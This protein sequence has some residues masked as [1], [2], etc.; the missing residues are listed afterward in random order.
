MTNMTPL[1][2]FR[3]LV[4]SVG[5]QDQI[6]LYS[7]SIL[8]SALALL[9]M[10]A[11][12]LVALVLTPLISG[13][14][15]TI[16][17]IGNVPNADLPPYLVAVVGLLAFKN[18]LM[19]SLSAMVLKRLSKIETGFGKQ[20]FTYNL[21]MPWALRADKPVI[22]IMRAAD[23][24]VMRSVISF[25]LPALGLP[26]LVASVVAIGIT[27]VVIQPV[28]AVTTIGY[29]GVVA[30]VLNLFVSKQASRVGNVE[31][32]ARNRTS[33][34]MLEML[35]ASKELILRKKTAESIDF[36]NKTHLEASRSYMHYTFL[37][38]SSRPLLEVALL[39]GAVLIG[40]VNYWVG[41]FDA[42]ISSIAL[43]GIAGFRIAPAIASIQSDYVSMKVTMPYVE[44]VL[45]E[46]AA[47]KSTSVR[48]DQN[49]EN[50]AVMLP[51]D[52]SAINFRKVNF[53]Y[54]NNPDR[55]VL[56][57]LSFELPLGQRFAIVGPSGSGKSTLVDLILGLL[58][59]TYG[60]LDIGTKNIL[61]ALPSWQRSIGYVPQ[62]VTLFDASIAQNVALTWGDDYDAQA[63]EDALNRA[64]LS[65][66][67][68]QLPEG[69]HTRIG[70]NGMLLSGG[71]RQRLGIARA[72]YTN[73]KVLV[74]DEAT[75]A[76]D[77]ATE[78][79]IA[80]MID[81]MEGSITIISI[82]HR[83]SSISQYENICYLAEG[84]LIGIGTFDALVSE[85]P[86]FA[87]QAALANTASL[88]EN[89]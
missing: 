66:L 40:V 6:F 20:I 5:R 26:A 57:D 52:A 47:A 41:G 34:L 61:E 64:Q 68:E 62:H 11:L 72:L 15:V 77:N 69:L 28:T 19:L 48:S 17:I 76:L 16:P 24:A 18:I 27:L 30:V 38:Q 43:F 1:S 78:N 14:S 82:A 2:G 75:S 3:Q 74:L 56:K 80:Q 33:T 63:V 65:S 59:P 86:E 25:L 50:Q 10:V 83:L 42:A 84:N 71:Q 58:A 21:N 70:E 60:E 81:A 4:G 87:H 32:T 37:V 55:L 46:L 7:Y 73:P 9:D 88:E 67:I 29:F 22:E 36:V 8:A 51:A 79:E 54:P 23:Y 31:Q 89:S 85:I 44:T 53:A 45:D 35:T 12:G 13:E 39:V 49:T